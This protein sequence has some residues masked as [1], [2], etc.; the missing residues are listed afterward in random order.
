[1]FPPEF[2][3]ELGLPETTTLPAV[4]AARVVAS[5]ARS[6]SAAQPVDNAQANARPSTAVRVAQGICRWRSANTRE[7]S[8]GPPTLI[9]ADRVPTGI[10]DRSRGKRPVVLALLARELAMF[11]GRMQGQPL[12]PGCSTCA[13]GGPLRPP[14][15]W[16]IPRR[17][18]C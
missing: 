2:W 6:A 14:N 18:P 10:H 11:S 13:A 8:W 12:R 17:L 1:M 4:A 9:D 7:S 16:R 3:S 5:N 15:R